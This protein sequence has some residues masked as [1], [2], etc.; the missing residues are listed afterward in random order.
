MS[1]S[2]NVCTTLAHDFLDTTQKM[3]MKMKELSV[4]SIHESI[5]MMNLMKMTQET[6]ESIRA[7]AA[8]ITGKADLCKMKVKCT[9]VGCNTEIPYRDKIVLQVI[10]MGMKDEHI[11]ARVLTQTAAGKLSTLK[12]II[13]Y[14]AAEETSILQS[15]DIC[16]ESSEA[17]I[18]AIGDK[19][20]YKLKRCGYCGEKPHG[21]NSVKERE[22]SCKGYNNKCSN[23]TKLHHLPSVCRSKKLA[24]TESS[25]E[26]PPVENS[27]MNVT[28][29]V[30]SST[31]GSVSTN[32]FHENLPDTLQYTSYSSVAAVIAQLRKARL[33]P[34]TTLPLHHHLHKLAGGCKISQPSPSPSLQVTVTLDRAAYG[35]LSLNMPR[36]VRKSNTRVE[37]QKAVCDTGAQVTVSPLQLLH[38]LGVKSDS[39]FSIST[40]INS[41][42]SAPVDIVGGIFLK[43]SATNLKTAVTTHTRQLVYVS[44]SIPTIYLSRNACTDLGI[45]SIN[46]PSPGE[47]DNTDTATCTSAETDDGVSASHCAIYGL[48]KCSNSGERASS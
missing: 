35:T 24:A 4:I 20:K 12:D 43:I 41:V 46:F 29:N 34:V 14:I 8:R 44:K 32:S 37:N 21:D 18:Q 13:D 2:Y 33:G 6:T 25:S 11:R 19:S 38:S 3:I 28:E 45:L 39:I 26:S 7:Y 30:P 23:C 47:F 42:N 36:L 22:K 16:H 48:P 17:T 40:S 15:K 31:I 1:N 9:K 10:Y 27:S 5:H